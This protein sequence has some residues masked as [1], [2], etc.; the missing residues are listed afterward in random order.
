[1]AIQ[2]IL[3][4]EYCLVSRLLCLYYRSEWKGYIEIRKM[5]EDP[6]FKSSEAWIVLRCHGHARG[7]S[8]ELCSKNP[9]KLN[10]INIF[11]IFKDVIVIKLFRFIIKCKL[12]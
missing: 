9:C 10:K 1:M 8:T 2:G 5:A 7:V 12:V 3:E 4:R 6:G 11:I